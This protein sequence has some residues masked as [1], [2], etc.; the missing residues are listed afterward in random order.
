M[1]SIAEACRR[2]L[3]AAPVAERRLHGGDLSEVLWLSLPGGAEA[4]VKRGGRSAAEARMLRALAAAGAPVP[5]VLGVVDDLLFLAAL[6]ER[7][8]DAEGWR[9]AGRALRALH[10][11][12]GPGYGWSEGYGFARI[13]IDNRP[14]ARWPDFWAERRLLP[15]VGHLPADLRR[16][17]ERLA[18]DLPQ[19]LPETPPPSLLHG[20]LWQGNLLF[21]GREAYFIDPACYHGHAEV[22]LAMLSLF[23]TP[24]AAFR[25]GYGAA[26]P[27]EAAR[28]PIY[29]LGPALMHVALFGAGYYSLVERL[30]SEAGA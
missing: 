2:L 23:G 11:T 4:V 27:G 1:S 17:T 3:G 13:A 6:E 10:E 5:E 20:D 7:A 19:R 14:L 26:G 18:R 12:H 24:P 25:Q 22:D 28:R 8:P 30:L 16:R 29:Q 21:S 9:A 15:L